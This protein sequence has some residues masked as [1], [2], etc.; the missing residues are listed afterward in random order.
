VPP[1]RELAGGR[2]GLG[3]DP[4]DPV[5]IYMSMFD[6]HVHRTPIE[7]VVR[8][9]AMYRASWSTRS[10]TK[11]AKTMSAS[12]HGAGAGVASG[13]ASPLIAGVIGRGS[14]HG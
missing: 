4:G 10:S 9:V 6:C 11:P 14:F 5:S 3:S 2:R 1:P 8:E 7:G 13:S 12:T